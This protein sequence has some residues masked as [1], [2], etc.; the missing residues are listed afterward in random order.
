[1]S[2][3][4]AILTPMLITIINIL[5]HTVILKR[6]LPVSTAFSLLMLNYIAAH[7]IRSL[8]NYYR[9]IANGRVAMARIE[10]FLRT[11]DQVRYVSTEGLAHGNSIEI[12]GASFSFSRPT[13][14]SATNDSS[15]PS[16]NPLKSSSFLLENISLTVS[17]GSHLCLYGPL[18]AGKSALL[19]SILGQTQHFKGV[20]RLS[21]LKLAYVSQQ[22][23]L[24][25][26]TIRANILFG[27]PLDNTRYYQALM[28]CGL[29][30]DIASL[31]DGEDTIIG[32]NGIK[33]SGGM[34]L[35]HL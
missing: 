19:A 6:D 1:M 4:L 34:L 20:V 25:N 13:A 7:G 28:Q 18:G 11:D 29:T 26:D 2:T 27:R 8:P 14:A 35:I 33:L 32:D 12:D 21:S 5:V 17:R 10:R 23:W 24:Q 9:E 15:S 30:V 22:P 16:T 3:S 31:A